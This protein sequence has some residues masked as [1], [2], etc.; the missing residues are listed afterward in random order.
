MP[1]AKTCSPTAVAAPSRIRRVRIGLPACGLALLLGSAPL[2]AQDS[3][4]PKEADVV[5]PVSAALCKDMKQHRVM[6]PGA[7][8]ACDRLRLVQ[9]GYVGFDG[10][11]HGDGQ[12]AVMDDNCTLTPGSLNTYPNSGHGIGPTRVDSSL[13]GRGPCSGRDRSGRDL[14]PTRRPT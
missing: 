13:R 8:V 9:F 2:V 5:V 1:S 3:E 11:S 14:G 12:V 4:R 6:N 7:P 10:Q